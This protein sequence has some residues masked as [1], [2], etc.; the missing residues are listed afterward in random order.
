MV[1]GPALIGPM[2]SQSLA[3]LMAPRSSS[4]RPITARSSIRQRWTFVRRRSRHA[5]KQLF[6]PGEFVNRYRIRI[7]PIKAKDT[8]VM[9]RFE[10]TD[11][12][13]KVVALH[14]RLGVVEYVD[15][16]DKHYREPDFTLALTRE[17]WAKLYLNQT[18]VA[19]LA[20]AGMLKNHRLRHGV[21]PR[22]RTVR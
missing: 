17:L 19:Q 7:D 13:N 11:A 20:S 21:R 2:K 8:D 18:T 6:E 1:A 16:A 10:F 5:E 12:D 3:P 14:V 15:N 22:A 9:I 4:A